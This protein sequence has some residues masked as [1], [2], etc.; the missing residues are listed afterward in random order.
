VIAKLNP[1]NFP[2]K[3][4]SVKEAAKLLDTGENKVRRLLE[5][6]E[7]HGVKLKACW[8]VNEAMLRCYI[9]IQQE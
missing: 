9:Q 3:S 2:S 7:I 8:R 4:I 1:R 6:G 5:T